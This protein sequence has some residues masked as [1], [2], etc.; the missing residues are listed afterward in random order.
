MAAEVWV[1]VAILLGT[2]CGL[3][4]VFIVLSSRNMDT[5]K[6]TTTP[7]P[8]KVMYGP[9]GASDQPDSGLGSIE[10]SRGSS[11]D[12]LP[13]IVKTVIGFYDTVY[14]GDSYTCKIFI[15]NTA[16]NADAQEKKIET[17]MKKD[18]QKKFTTDTLYGKDQEP[19][20]IKIELFAPNFNVS[21]SSRILEIPAG[22]VASS[23]HVIAP[24]TEIKTT[25]LGKKQVILV[26][27]DQILGEA[28]ATEEI[29]LGSLEYSVQ[30]E[31][32]AIPVQIESEIKTQEKIKYVSTAAGAVA[33]VITAVAT[34]LA[35]LGI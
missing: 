15:F 24:L 12:V 32:A 26:S 7:E 10:K 11:A 18:L 27:F 16:Q 28:G 2:I 34:A 25:I 14:I 29:H 5:L 22:G 8:V 30:I 4:I 20:K 1:T 31:K 3:S 21:P 17:I 23:T 35:I 9:K 13:L 33:A 6:K 19:A